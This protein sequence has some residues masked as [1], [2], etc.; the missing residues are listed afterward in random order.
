MLALRNPTDTNS[1][2]TRGV[3]VPV[4]LSSL[5]APVAVAARSR[6]AVIHKSVTVINTT[7]P[8][9]VVQGIKGGA[10]TEYKFN[11]EGE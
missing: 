2:V 4:L 8:V 9:Y 7:R 5:G 1:V 11:K 10:V 6:S 3:T